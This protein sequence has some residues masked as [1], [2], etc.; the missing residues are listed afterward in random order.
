M[1]L[2]HAKNVPWVF[3]GEK[4]RLKNLSIKKMT[5]LPL[6]KKSL[7]VLAIGEQAAAIYYE[8]LNN[9]TFIF[10]YYIDTAKF[11]EPSYFH[12]GKINFLYSG[13]M[14][15]RKGVHI[16]KEAILFLGNKY[17]SKVQFHLI[18]EGKLLDTLKRDLKGL[19]N[20]EFYGFVGYEYLPSIYEVGD[21]FLFPSLYDGWGVALIEGMA[22]GMLPVS[23]FTTGAAVQNILNGINGYIIPPNNTSA[24]LSILEH[25]VK[26]REIIPE[27]GKLAR[28]YTLKHGD[29]RAGV[30]KLLS[31]LQSI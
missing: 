15:K 11:K 16:L 14:V 28:E 2:L 8:I 20:V 5:I 31:I 26:N 30:S 25:I 7:A 13:Q 23:T 3:W 6:L 1:K 29:V 19:N 4:I 22:A 27:M 24:L 10:P 17:K 18:G 9:P 12:R 21:V